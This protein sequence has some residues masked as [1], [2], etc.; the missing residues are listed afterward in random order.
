MV[1]NGGGLNYCL[2]WRHG[3]VVR[4]RVNDEKGTG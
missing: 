4:G 1:L 3:D 2:K